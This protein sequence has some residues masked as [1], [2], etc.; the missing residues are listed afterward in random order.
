MTAK[1]YY[2]YISDKYLML[3]SCQRILEDGTCDELGIMSSIFSRN[4]DPIPEEEINMLFT[5]GQNNC[6]EP[7][8]FA[9]VSHQGKSG[10][11]HKQKQ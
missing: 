9:P 6:I 8:D 11:H 7:G 4:L 1:A 2:T 3:Y 5:Y 10:Q